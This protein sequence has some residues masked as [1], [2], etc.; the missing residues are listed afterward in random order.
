MISLEIQVNFQ[1]QHLDKHKSFYKL[2]KNK[3]EQ[4]VLIK[5]M[6]LLM[7]LDLNQIKL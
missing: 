6:I 7:E 2:L 1:T 4:V 5:I 3:Q